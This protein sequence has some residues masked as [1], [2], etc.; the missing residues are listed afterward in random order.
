MGVPLVDSASALR[1][2][3]LAATLRS[4]E[5]ALGTAAMV[6][7][8]HPVRAAAI[9]IRRQITNAHTR[10]ATRMALCVAATDIEVGGSRRGAMARS[11]MERS[12]VAAIARMES[13]RSRLTIGIEVMALHRIESTEAP[14]F[15]R[16]ARRDSQTV[17]TTKVTASRP[18]SVPHLLAF[19]LA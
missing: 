8:V 15:K 16:V 18:H 1:R 9:D 14:A 12:K 4:S 3:N 19:Q 6:T 10:A 11:E 7:L 2:I 13:T 17:D 5:G